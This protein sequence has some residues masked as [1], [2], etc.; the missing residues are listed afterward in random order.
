MPGENKIDP[1]ELKFEFSRSGG[2]GGQNVNKVETSVQLLF[3]VANSGSLPDSVKERLINIAGR[4]I[5]KDGILLI[6]SSKHRSQLKNK[7]DVLDKIEE[8][9][10]KASKP[11]KPRKKTAPT[12]ASKEKRLTEKKLTAEKKKLRGK[13]TGNE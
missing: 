5:N 7:Q 4:R 2:P 1:K 8:L 12:K 9:I 6:T 10:E 11:P 3:D 13:V